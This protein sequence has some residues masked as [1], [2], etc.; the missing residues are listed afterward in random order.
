MRARLPSSMCSNQRVEATMSVISRTCLLW[1]MLAVSGV[2]GATGR[3]HALLVGVSVYPTLGKDLQLGGPGND[4]RLYR[5]LLTARGVPAANLQVLADGVKN[6]GSP[7]RAAILQ[8]LSD[9]AAKAAEGDFVF[10]LFAGHGSQQPAGAQSGAEPDGLDEIFL[11]RDVG[12]W[13]GAVGAVANAISDNELGAAIGRIRARGAFVWAVFDTCHSGTITRAMAVRGQRDRQIRPEA[14]GI[15]PAALAK[16]RA[17]AVPVTTRGGAAGEAGAL[18][19]AGDGAG[20]YVF[21]YAAQSHELAPERL[22]PD[23]V[24]DARP[25]GLFSF[26][27]YQVLT[28]TPAVSYRQAV[29]RVIQVY[30]ARGE[31]QPSPLYEGSKL[32]ATVFGASAGAALTQWRV[33][34]RGKE[35]QL[36]AG[37]LHSVTPQ[38]LLALVAEPTAARTAVL[39]YVQVARAD[40]STAT[41]VPVAHGGRGALS[42]DAVP[43]GAYARPV[44]LKVDFRLRVG[45]PTSGAHCSA[46]SA[47]LSQAIDTLRG[48]PKVGARTVWVDGAQTAD[49]Y[50]CQKDRS[51]LFLDGSRSVSGAATVPGVAMPAA[52]AQA[53][54]RLATALKEQLTRVARV[55]NLERVVAGGAGS[56][57]IGVQLQWVRTCGAAESGCDATPQTLQTTSRA[58]LQDGDRLIVTLHNRSLQPVDVTVLYVDAGY[59]ITTLYPHRANEGQRFGP[60][61]KYSFSVTVNAQPSGFEQMLVLTS[62]AAPQSPI[63]SFTSLAQASMST[64]ATRGSGTG[65]FLELMEEAAFGS[66]PFS[67]RGGEGENAAPGV[68]TYAWTVLPRN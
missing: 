35:L 59:G 24:L 55:V 28:A 63:T 48:D 17:A 12:R 21:M 50:L 5:D 66:T 68:A 8:G 54:D 40:A 37:R 45:L 20:D 34:R 43:V 49:V 11:P 23:D 36:R 29:E 15:D 30:L 14:L 16:A 42:S 58:Q 62:P 2:A 41:V 4:V 22:L 51:V 44:D 65:G 3:T 13:D 1:L 6:A 56:E 9:L 60:D 53:A 64:F 33:D 67:T 31:Q 10:L 7:T 57:Q 25:Q 19:D 61:E 46:P 27:L 18:A 38:S 47:L 32:D 26:T 39:G 52:A